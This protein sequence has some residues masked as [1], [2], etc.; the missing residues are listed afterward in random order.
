MEVI[1]DAA[2]C[3]RFANGT[4]VT[5]GAYDGV[6]LGHRA[7]IGEV[8]Q[9][10]AALGAATVV[11]TFDKHPAVVVRPESAPKLLTDLEQKLELFAST[12]V[13]YTLV[14]HFDEARP[15]QY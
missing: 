10:A 14:I 6:H 12:G 13:D 2:A 7:L 3:P 5:I 4:V 9:R 1:N 11:I 8:K 15:H